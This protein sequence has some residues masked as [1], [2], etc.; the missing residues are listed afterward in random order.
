MPP[1]C[2]KGRD[3]T[4]DPVAD[5]DRDD[6]HPEGTD[7]GRAELTATGHGLDHLGRRGATPPTDEAFHSKSSR[8]S[9]STSFMRPHL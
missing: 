9:R 5:R 2:P 8:R 7:D 4:D 1:G 3:R 6:R